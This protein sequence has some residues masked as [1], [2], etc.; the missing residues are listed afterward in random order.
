MECMS[1][2]SLASCQA[3]QYNINMEVPEIGSSVDQLSIYRKM[4]PWRRVATGCALHDFAHK[5]LVLHLTKEHPDTP[6]P[7]ILGMAA[8]RFLGDAARVL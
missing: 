4:P 1:S 2:L 5:R 8:K 6:K 7:E 3:W